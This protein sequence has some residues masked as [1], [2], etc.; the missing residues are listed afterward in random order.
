MQKSE[1]FLVKATRQTGNI[2][3]CS[4]THSSRQAIILYYYSV[5]LQEVTP[6]TPCLE[7][8]ALENL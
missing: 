8:I 5:G 6:C 4:S 3:W 7:K 2:N 1:T